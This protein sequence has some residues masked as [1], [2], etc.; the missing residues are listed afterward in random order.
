M[1]KEMLLLLAL[2]GLVP[3]GINAICFRYVS[4]PKSLNDIKVE[5]D[6]TKIG[7]YLPTPINKIGLSRG[8]G[9]KYWSVRDPKS[10]KKQYLLCHC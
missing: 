5:V 4:G 7:S 3:M 9:T 10:T 1:K 6:V 2:G 8:G